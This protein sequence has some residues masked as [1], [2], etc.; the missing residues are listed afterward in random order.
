MPG[1]TATPLGAQANLRGLPWLSFVALLFQ[2]LL[3]RGR[4]RPNTKVLVLKDQ[5][6]NINIKIQ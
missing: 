3:L 2:P 1:T 5:Y 6:F 4:E